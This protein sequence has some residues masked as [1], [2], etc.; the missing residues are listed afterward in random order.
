MKWG[1]FKDYFRG[2]AWKRLT[3]HEIDPTVSNG[4][5]FQGVNTLRKVLGNEDRTEWPTTYM[6]LR[7]NDDET[8]IFNSEASWYDSRRSDPNRSAEYR[9]YYPEEAAA[10]RRM[11]VG[12]PMVIAL[13]RDGDLLILFAARGSE[14]E[15]ELELLFGIDPVETGKLHV[16][17]LEAPVAL[18]F[19]SAALL[20]QF[21]IGAPPRPTGSDADV[22]SSL[23]DQLA[24]THPDGLPTGV[25]VSAQVR[26]RLPNVDAI[27]AP[28]DALFR[29]IEAE[30]AIYREWEDRKISTRLAKGFVNDDGSP[31]VPAFRKFSMTLRQSRVSRAG[32]ALQ[33][34][35]RALLD[36]AKLRYVMEPEIDGGESPDFLFPS[37]RD[38]EDAFF[39]ESK[40]RMLAV[41]FT[42][43]DRW[44]QVLNE[45]KRIE[46]KHLLTL[47]AAISSKQMRLM[48]SAKLQLVIPALIRSKY[49][50]PQ[51]REILS[52]SEFL[53]MIATLQ[54]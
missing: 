29:W 51:A 28:D 6:L 27:G 21:G 53:R 26:M 36:S 10:V 16:R 37:V 50:D 5:E 54:A 20:E 12:D 3:A 17:P 14:R 49:P 24:T 46:T 7:D 47:E 48:G 52:V 39:P 2:F 40:L 13:K 33:Y 45:A 43:K 44:R 11:K 41:K 4:H 30:A 18:D 19:V 9:L 31:N 42:A 35:V 15:R 38:Y 8:E 25:D 23:A 32:K 22:V 1:D 34:H